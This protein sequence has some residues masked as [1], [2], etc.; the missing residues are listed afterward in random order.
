MSTD[1]QLA[2]PTAQQ[3][4]ARAASYR[5]NIL[6]LLAC[7]QAIAY[8]DRVNFAV[9]GPRL[10]QVYHTTT[11]QIGFVV[12]VFNWAFPFSLLPAGTPEGRNR[13]RR[14][15]PLGVGTWSLAS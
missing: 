5:W 11:A 12:D 9:V 14:S 1:A 13:P 6:A 15:Y 8:I 4:S 3:S 7:S 2:A 10:I